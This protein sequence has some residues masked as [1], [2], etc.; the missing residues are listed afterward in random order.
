MAPVDVETSGV[1]KTPKFCT[2]RWIGPGIPVYLLP[3]AN[4]LV[5]VMFSVVY[6][7]QSFTIQGHP[8]YCPVPPPPPP[9][10]DTLWLCSTPHHSGTTPPRTCSTWTSLLSPSTT[11]WY[12]QICLL[13]SLYCR[14]AG[15]WHSTEMLSFW[16]MVTSGWAL[17]DSIR[18]WSRFS[19]YIP[20]GLNWQICF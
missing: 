3:L 18:F 7:C 12:V 6:V 8:L 5:K 4:E 11:P 10:R 20:C 16:T 17:H 1:C 9:S 19:L 13:W 14:Q 15:G 2:R